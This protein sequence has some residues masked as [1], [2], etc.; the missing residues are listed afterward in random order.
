[1]DVSEGDASWCR[2]EAG[3]WPDASLVYPSATS[4][5]PSVTGLADNRSLATCP[6]QAGG[7]VPGSVSAVAVP[8]DLAKCPPSFGPSRF[9]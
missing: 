4:T 9:T 7:W 1:M 6:E 5:A 2:S 3:G 8:R